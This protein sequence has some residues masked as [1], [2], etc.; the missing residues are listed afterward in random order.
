MG[1]EPSAVSV[2][3]K[4]LS[5]EDLLP[6]L[7]GQPRRIVEVCVMPVPLEKHQ[8]VVAAQPDYLP[9]CC[10]GLGLEMTEELDNLYRVRSAVDHI[11]GL[12]KNRILSRPVSPPVNQPSV[13]EDLLKSRKFTVNVSNN[14]MPCG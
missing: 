12:D 1:I 5:G 8:F 10:L 14:N 3:C 9:T 7:T 6:K 2:G 4:Q 13:S 11:P